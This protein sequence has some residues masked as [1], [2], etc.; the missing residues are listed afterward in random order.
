AVDEQSAGAEVGG[1]RLAVEAYAEH[2]ER[3]VDAS[4]GGD[5]L[6]IARRDGDPAVNEIAVGVK[7]RHVGL[8]IDAYTEEANLAGAAEVRH[9]ERLELPGRDR[10][11]ALAQGPVRREAGGEDLPADPRGPYAE[12]DRAVTRA[13]R[14]DYQLVEHSGRDAEPGLR[15]VPVHIEE[16]SVHLVRILADAE[17]HHALRK[18]IGDDTEKPR[19]G[20]RQRPGPR[21][22]LVDIL[23]IDEHLLAE[24]RYREAERDVRRPAVLQALEFEAGAPA[25][26]TFS[27]R[28]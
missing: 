12:Q 27:T 24:L 14:A 7:A 23:H 6:K 22:R 1:I 5:G 21:N 15:Q 16:R 8:V 3:G 20:R 18:R 9:R 19:R 26:P 13:R 28:P 11:P 10:E 4:R 2:L 25:S 17:R